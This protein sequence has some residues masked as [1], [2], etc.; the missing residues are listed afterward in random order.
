MINELCHTGNWGYLGNLGT[1]GWVGLF[2]N[3]IFW[4]GLLTSLTLLILGAVR[5]SRTRAATVTSASGQSATKENLQAQFARGQVTREQY[6]LMK[7]DI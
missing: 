5:R 4:V 6:E 7:Q 2:L 3:L 1:W